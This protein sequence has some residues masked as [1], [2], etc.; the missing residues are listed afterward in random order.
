MLK[1]KHAFRLT[2]DDNSIAGVKYRTLDQ[3]RNIEIKWK[4][5]CWTNNMSANYVLASSKP[6]FVS[7]LAAIAKD[8]RDV[9]NPNT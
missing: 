1:G 9:G 5:N 7:P 2:D 3:L 4:E 6:S 8:D